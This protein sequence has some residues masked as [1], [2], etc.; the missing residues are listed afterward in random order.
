MNKILVILTLS[1]LIPTIAK[2]NCR[3]IKDND[4]KQACLA[5]TKNE[6][7]YCWQIKDNDA[8]Q[9]CLAQIK[10]EKSYCWQIRNNDKKQACLAEF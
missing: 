4:A 3:Q 2:A 9:Y 6:Y 8:K 7:S 10:R 5:R 1:I